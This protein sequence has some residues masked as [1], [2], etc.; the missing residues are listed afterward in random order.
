MKVRLINRYG[1]A[2]NF[3]SVRAAKP[4]IKKDRLDDYETIIE[5]GEKIRVYKDKEL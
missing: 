1:Y 4:H 2:W 5:N 3:I